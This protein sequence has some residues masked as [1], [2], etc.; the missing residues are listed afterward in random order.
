MEQRHFQRLPIEIPVFLRGVD[1]KGKEFLEFTLATNISGGGA[2]VATRRDLTR[3]SRL[4]LEI[5]TTPVRFS[6]A[7]V[8][9]KRAFAGRIV[10]KISKETYYLYGVRFARPLVGAYTPKGM[11]TPAKEL[12]SESPQH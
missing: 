3:G 10:S 4:R 1:K 6:D 2:V 11:E 8:T 5:P 12:A 9:T 7:P